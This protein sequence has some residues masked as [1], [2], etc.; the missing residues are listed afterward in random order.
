MVPR[1][2]DFVVPGNTKHRPSGSWRGQV[3]VM[4]LIQGW[5]R[6]D[7]LRLGL[8]SPR[9]RPHATDFAVYLR[10]FPFSSSSFVWTSEQHLH[11]SCGTSSA[12]LSSLVQAYG[13]TFFLE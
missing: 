7:F 11:V 9:P 8:F 13:W 10:P 6:L 1:Y 2:I 3:N 4:F 12:M 5:A